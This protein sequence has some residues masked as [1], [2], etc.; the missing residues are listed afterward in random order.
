MYDIYRALLAPLGHSRRVSSQQRP[1]I[2]CLVT[3]AY[4]HNRSKRNKL[5]LRRAAGM[6]AWAP[7]LVA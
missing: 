6:L 4:I 2:A 1:S 3:E 5:L 7:A